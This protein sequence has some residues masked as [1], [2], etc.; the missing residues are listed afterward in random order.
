MGV[1]PLSDGLAFP[2]WGCHGTSAQP[3]GCSFQVGEDYY[4]DNKTIL[5]RCLYFNLSRPCEDFNIWGSFVVLLV[6][7]TILTFMPGF[8]AQSP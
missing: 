2:G 7:K 6:F 5:L 4:C 3:M 1:G 8:N